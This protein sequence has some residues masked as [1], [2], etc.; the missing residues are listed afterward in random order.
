LLNEWVCKLR[1]I[2]YFWFALCLK[3]FSEHLE[4]SVLIRSV[5]RQATG[6]MSGVRYPAGTNKFSELHS[7][8]NG[9]GPTQVSVEW[10]RSA[11]SAGIKRLGREIDPS[12]P[13]SA[14]IKNDGA[15]Y[16]I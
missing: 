14:E 4:P 9:F 3:M 2:E 6:W 10:A 7:A 16:D 8:K 15:M 13:P 5:L 11:L 1:V 12:P